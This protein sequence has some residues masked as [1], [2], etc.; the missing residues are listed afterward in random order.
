MDYKALTKDQL[1]DF[2][3]SVQWK[4][5]PMA[6]QL[7]TMAWVLGEELDRAMLWLDIGTGKTLT[8]LYL[9]HYLWGCERIFVISPSSVVTT[10]EEQVAEHTGLTFE[11]LTG[12]RDERKARLRES[13]ADVVVTNYEGLKLLFGEKRAVPVRTGGYG[14]EG[15]W[16][17]KNKYVITPEE[18]EDW[19]FDCIIADEIHRFKRY[20]TVQSRIGHALSSMTK[21]CLMLT[22]TPISTDISDL[23]SEYRVLDGGETLGSSLRH[24]HKTYF[25]QGGYKKK[26]WIPQAGAVEDIMR[27]VSPVTIRFE[28]TECFDLPPVV[29]EMR[30]VELSVEQRKLSNDLLAGLSVE[31]ESGEVNVS[32]VLSRIMKLSQIAGGFIKTGNSVTRMK[33]NPKMD[34]LMELLEEVYGKAVVFHNFVEEGRM[35]EETCRKKKIKFR[36]LRA[37]VKDK[38]ASY[39]EFRADPEVKVLIAHPASGGEGINLPEANVEIFYSQGYSGAPVRAQA[40]GRILRLG[41]TQGCVFVDLVGRNSV[42]EQMQKSLHQHQDLARLALDWVRQYG[43]KTA[44]V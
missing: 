42:D 37:E 43:A 22:G 28:R 11:A 4:T 32:N 3:E 25:Y 5:K 2:F 30:E 8:A 39:K 7:A 35:I 6:H 16:E 19:P 44:N 18:Y 27:R 12:K 26:E 13:T 34:A 15:R 41:Q 17:T 24:F 10:W 38:E 36:S 20:S 40:E 31:V 29:R 23:W 9:A 14:E 1:E 33:K 21:N